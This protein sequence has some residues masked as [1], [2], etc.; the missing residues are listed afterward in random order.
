MVVETEEMD[1]KLDRIE[2]WMLVRDS[3]K[4]QGL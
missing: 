2:A 1:Q 4:A 3:Q